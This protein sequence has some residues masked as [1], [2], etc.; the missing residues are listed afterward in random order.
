MN[1]LFIII[2]ASV[3]FCAAFAALFI[4]FIKRGHYDDLKTPA[5]RV[6]MEDMDEQ[7]KPRKL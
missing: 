2:T 3:F 6:L 4:F 7:S 5:L 1:A